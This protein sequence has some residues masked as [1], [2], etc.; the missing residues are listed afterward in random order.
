MTFDRSSKMR[1]PDS[2]P[3]PG[4]RPS[5]PSM[6]S[7]NAP[8]IASRNDNHERRRSSSG[9]SPELDAE[10]GEPGSDAPPPSSSRSGFGSKSATARRSTASSLA[11]AAVPSSAP[12][13]RKRHVRSL[14]SDDFAG[15]EEHEEDEE[16]DSDG[17]GEADSE[18]SDFRT[19]W[20]NVNTSSRRKSNQVGVSATK[21]SSLGLED[22]FG[23]RHSMAV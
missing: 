5:L 2:V 11:S 1:K 4:A 3:P 12:A 22:G 8:A 17:G 6:A 14:S 23:R 10:V 20:A 16:L 13:K 19:T 21:A 9:S 7:S 15:T 18:Y